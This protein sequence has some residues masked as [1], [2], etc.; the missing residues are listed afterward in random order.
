MPVSGI[1]FVRGIP[2][3]LRQD[4]ANLYDE[5]FGAKFAVAVPSKAARIDLLSIL[6]NP[7]GMTRVNKAPL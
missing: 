4:A 6:K 5:A 1:E 3:E 7:W 2:E